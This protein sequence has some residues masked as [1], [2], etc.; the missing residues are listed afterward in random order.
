MKLGC[1]IIGA[2]FAGAVCAERF[3][4]AYGKSVLVVKKRSHIGG[5]AFDIFDD[6]SIL[7]HRYNPHIFHTKIEEVWTF[8]VSPLGGRIQGKLPGVTRCVFRTP[9]TISGSYQR[10]G[11]S[12]R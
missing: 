3:A 9:C 2:G 6:F 12:R 4:N 10:T 7:I 8:P 5:N 1:L 11:P